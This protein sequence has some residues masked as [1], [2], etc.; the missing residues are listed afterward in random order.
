MMMHTVTQTATDLSKTRQNTT[1]H[2]FLS[3]DASSCDKEWLMV[4]AVSAALETSTSLEKQV[5][6]FPVRI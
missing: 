1:I 3:M 4:G 5:Y 6:C 2:H